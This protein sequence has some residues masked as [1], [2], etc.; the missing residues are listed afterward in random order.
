MPTRK[1]FCQ[2]CLALMLAGLG[3]PSAFGRKGNEMK[4]EEE[5]KTKA[6]IIGACG[7]VCS[8][9]PACIATQ[10]NDDILRAR[11]ATEWS[12]MYHADIKPED[13]HCDG[14]PSDGPRL[15]SHCLECGIRACARGRKLV[16]C[17]PCPEYACKKLQDFF[18]LV[19]QAR[20]TL[21]GL[22]KQ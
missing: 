8:E 17:A 18:A 10:K 1:Q 13:I 4:K 5:E 15:F 6:R 22:R 20:E 7:I 9:C 2:S 11:T 19:P 21:D 12:A 14:C 16:T 3:A